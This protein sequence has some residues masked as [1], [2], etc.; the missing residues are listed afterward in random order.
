MPKN[1]N[2]I[3]T[4]KINMLALLVLSSQVFADDIVS[5]PGQH[6]LG[7][8]TRFQD[9][10]DPL[11][12][13]AQAFT[14]RIKLTSRF[15]LD[16]EQQWQFLAEPNFV[17]AF[18]DGDYNSVTIKKLTSPIPDPQGFNWSKVNVSYDSMNDWHLTLG[19]QALAFDNERMV[20][21]IEFWQTP[22][23]FDALKFDFND[24]INW[25][26]QYAYTN[27]VHRIFGQDST[28]VIPK[29]DIRYGLIDKRPVNE[30]GEHKLNAHLLNIS[31]QTDNNLTITAYNYLVENKNQAKFS[32]NTFGMRLSDEFKPQKIKYRYT[33]EFANQQDAYDN[34]D[35]YQAWYSLLEGSVQYKSHIF[36]LSQEILSEDNHHG[37]KTPLGTNHKFQGWADVFTGY[38]MQTGLRDQ[39]VT[40][41]GRIKKLRW[42]AV[43]HRFNSYS[44]S[45]HIGNELDIELAY[46]ATRKW[47]FKFVYADY[48]VKNGLKYFPKA[49]NDL[50]TWF[51]SVAYNI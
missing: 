30:L 8:R 41:R 22:Q 38:A 50:A 44:S 28:S 6:E 25:H 34:P 9:V 39:Y 2:I 37:F 23:N 27:K 24:H 12:G 5:L 19:R 10:I 15:T 47:E 14:T 13:G 33:I 29:D 48:R 43:Y 35:N 32:L 7:M 17:Y 11:L 31:Y 46:R 16:D 21:A 18:N 3:K 36:Q 49:S 1:S 20:G 4:I 42:R 40:Y 26:L 45:N 51:A